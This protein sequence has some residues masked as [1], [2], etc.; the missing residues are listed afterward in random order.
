MPVY[1]FDPDKLFPL[2]PGKGVLRVDAERAYQTYVRN[3]GEQ[4]T[5]DRV[6]ERGGFGVAEFVYYFHGLC[7]RGPEK[8]PTKP[9]PSC[10]GSGEVMDSEEGGI[11]VKCGIC[12]GAGE[13]LP[14]HDKTEAR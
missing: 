9:C 2:H 1:G 6:G 14:A 5:L 12:F 13:V 3:F 7:P 8:W 10:H 11:I 4:Q